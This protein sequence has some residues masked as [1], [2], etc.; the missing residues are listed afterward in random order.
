MSADE[1]EAVIAALG[2]VASE[3]KAAADEHERQ[4]D[5]TNIGLIHAASWGALGHAL[6]IVNEH[7]LRAAQ[8]TE[9]TP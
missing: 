9:A 3:I 2:E 1:Q 5:S 8:G 6:R 7:R 4:L